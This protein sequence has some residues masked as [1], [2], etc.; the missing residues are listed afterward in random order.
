VQILGTLVGQATSMMSNVK[1][2]LVNI[3]TQS[4]A[5]VAGNVLSLFEVILWQAGDTLDI[6]VF[7]ICQFACSGTFHSE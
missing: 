1:R 2:M 5:K 3:S 6:I 4:A 7:L